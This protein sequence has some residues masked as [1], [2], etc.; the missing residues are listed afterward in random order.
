MSLIATVVTAIYGVAAV[1]GAAIGYL[2][3]AHR[4]QPG[5]TP[6]LGLV[7]GAMWWSGALFLAGQA[8]GVV[9]SAWL[10]R[11][12][13]LGVAVIVA[14][15]LLFALEYTGRADAMTPWRL[16]L[17]AVHPAAI[18]A[19]VVLDPGGLFFGGIEAAPGTVTG[20]SFS[21]GPA[22]WVHA[23]YSYCVVAVALVVLFQSMYRSRRLYRWQFVLLAV[24]IIVTATANY[25]Y[26]AGPVPF[27]TAPLGIL[28]AA[29]L[30]AVAITRY[31]LIHV[32]P[33]ARQRVLDTMTDGVIV[34]D[35][36]D[37]IVEIN[38]AARE[39]AAA[40][41]AD[42]VVVGRDVGELFA[43]RP[44]LEH[45]YAELT[46]TRSQSRVETSL[47][48]AYVDV[49][50]SP[51]GTAGDARP[52]ESIGEGAGDV[53]ASGPLGGAV[54]G[55][56]WLFIVRDVTAR[57]ERERALR[58]RNEQLDRFATVVSHDLRNP[59]GIAKGHVE[60][61]RDTGD[62][63][64]LEPVADAL[65]RM[66]SLIDEVLTIAREGADVTDTEP[67]RLAAVAE[68]AWRSVDAGAATY[69]VVDDATVVA[70]RPKLVRI[71]E[72]LFRNAVEH[73]STSPGSQAH[74]D[75]GTP[76]RTATRG[77][78]RTPLAR[79]ARRRPGPTASAM[80]TPATRPGPQ[81]M[82]IPRRRRA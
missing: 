34:V 43:E 78:P 37:R 1:S 76:P 8:D 56:G 77:T 51:L 58:R 42:D 3:W 52:A 35:H 44:T 32:V 80:P 67:V 57:E 22:F 36:A 64:R 12:T 74:Q 31:R 81:G 11:S 50:A 79:P 62:V 28:L 21:F 6:L 5:A 49:T 23:L 15:I 65:D 69:R 60:I 72:N 46:A 13:Y 29:G 19:F 2:V 59:L 54:A 53:D 66:E 38:P 63:S 39:M 27:D 24:A 40:V 17:L 4:D 68:A 16:G 70:D 33:A 45:L 20:V 26:I 47:G 71:L 73:G 14:C 75:A 18:S 25:A 82:R 48:D 41:L 7:A 55:G 9:A 10:Q 30:V 61:A